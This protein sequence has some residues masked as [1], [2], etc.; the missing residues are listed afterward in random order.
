MGRM[1]EQLKLTRDLQLPVTIHI[2]NQMFTEDIREQCLEIL[3]E[4]LAPQHQMY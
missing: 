1:R 3:S 4:I 2:H